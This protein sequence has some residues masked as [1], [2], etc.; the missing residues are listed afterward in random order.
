[1]NNSRP[2]ALVEKE[3]EEF[4]ILI[5]KDESE[6]DFQNFF[7]NNLRFFNA[8]GFSHA[9]P[10]PIIESSSQGKYIP[11]FI[12]CR[13][14]GLWELL[15]LKRPNTK[16]LKNKTRRDALYNEMQS[17]LS[18]C[19]DYQEQLKDETVRTQFENR[20]GVTM[21]PGFPVTIVAGLSEHVDQVKTTKMLDRSKNIS[22][23][24]F[25]QALGS[26]QAWYAGKYPQANHWSGYTVALL[27]Q[28]DTFKVE[29]GCII[30]IGWVSE[31]NRISLHRKSEDVL[32]L[33]IID[34]NGL[35][36][37]NDFISPDKTV[38]RSVPLMIHV[39][40]VNDML[41]IVLEAD[42]LQIVDIRSSNIDVDLPMPSP[43]TLGNDFEESGSACFFKGMFLTRNP[44]LSMNERAMLRA[45]MKEKCYDH[46]T[47]PERVIGG[48]RFGPNQFMYNEGH[49]FFDSDHEF[50]TNMVQRN[51]DFRPKT[52]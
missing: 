20:Y 35:S 14:D 47:N 12:V 19:I 28:L 41:R 18:Q 22:L 26:I 5:Q 2:C 8:L 40:P 10:H 48:L 1:M 13:N 21:H 3:I 16:V 30:D 51:N 7:E 39:F 32:T 43:L 9:I 33:R 45:H 4:S 11:D 38:G 6:Q 17:Y 27:Y 42:G 15:E 37:S 23:A 31:K 46:R 24:T 49:P 36:T 52:C 50:S 34:K 25:D 29:N 44:T